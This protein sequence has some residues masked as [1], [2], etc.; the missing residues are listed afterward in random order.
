MIPRGHLVVSQSGL[1]TT[2]TQRAFHR[3]WLADVHLFTS[4]SRERLA[5]CEAVADHGVEV[6]GVKVGRCRGHLHCE[7]A[8]IGVPGTAA[9]AGIEQEGLKRTGPPGRG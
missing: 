4:P 9:G 7:C 6:G 3:T 1:K 8:A 5:L 2:G